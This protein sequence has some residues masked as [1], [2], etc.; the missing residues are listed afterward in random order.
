MKLKIPPLVKA[1]ID[2]SEGYYKH[3]LQIIR[4]PTGRVKYPE[5][6]IQNRKDR[7]LGPSCSVVG[8]GLLRDAL[9]EKQT[10]SLDYSLS[11]T[12]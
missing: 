8:L 12:R 10:F 2:Q 5:R 1:L 3:Y 7:R 9:E 6:C 11:D 4:Q